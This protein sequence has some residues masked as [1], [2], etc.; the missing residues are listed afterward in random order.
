MA[1]F[2]VWMSAWPSS[3]LVTSPS[4]AQSTSAGPAIIIWAVSRTITE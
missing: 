1:P 3:S 4:E 2:E